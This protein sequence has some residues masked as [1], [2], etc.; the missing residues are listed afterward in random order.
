MQLSRIFMLIIPLLFCF[1]CSQEKSAYEL[2]QALAKKEKE[3]P[4]IYLSIENSKLDYN[5]TKGGLFKKSKIDGVTFTG[6]VV[7]SATSATYKDAKV[8]LQF[9]SESGDLITG[10]EFL[11]NATLP[12]NSKKEFS[13][14]IDNSSIPSNAKSHIASARGGKTVY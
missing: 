5:R 3:T 11:I 9:F 1:A 7:N 8:L 13:F 12:P 6:K 2:K 14:K 10:Q 4:F